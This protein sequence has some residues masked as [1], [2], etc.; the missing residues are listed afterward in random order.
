MDSNQLNFINI[1]IPIAVRIY[2]ERSKTEQTRIV[3]DRLETY[4]SILFAH[5]ATI[6]ELQEGGCFQEDAEIGDILNVL[7]KFGKGIMEAF[8]IAKAAD[9]TD[10]VLDSEVLK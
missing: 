3:M 5:I 8:D 9:L 7:G 2:G 10:D 6:G 4:A 1:Q